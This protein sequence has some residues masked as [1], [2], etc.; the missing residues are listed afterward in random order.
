[1]SSDGIVLSQ[2]PSSTCAVDRVRAQHLLGGHRGHVAPQHRG[3]PHVGLPEGD[4]R[5]VQRDAARLV[6][7]VPDGGGDLVQM[8]VARGQVGRRVRDRDVRPPGERV[9]RQPP[10]HPGPVEIRVAAVPAYHCA[11]RSSFT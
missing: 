3:R 10:P 9:R 5:Q 6:D 1:M 8:R 2:P 4:D 11:L 7:P